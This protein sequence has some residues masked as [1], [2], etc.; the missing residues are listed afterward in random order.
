M[1]SLFKLDLETWEEGEWERM[2]ENLNTEWAHAKH[3]G[4]VNCSTQAW[5]FTSNT[6]LVSKSKQTQRASLEAQRDLSDNQSP[7]RCKVYRNVTIYQGFIHILNMRNNWDGIWGRVDYYF[8]CV[9]SWKIPNQT[10]LL[11]SWLRKS[12]NAKFGPEIL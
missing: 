1:R 3:C 10:M 12:Q 8:D 9:K 4:Q 6:R 5:G 2:R 11:R 7:P